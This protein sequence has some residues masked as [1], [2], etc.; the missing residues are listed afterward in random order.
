[1]SNV[2]RA[3]LPVVDPTIKVD[4]LFVEDTESGG[5]NPAVPPDTLPSNSSR[6]GAWVP[7]VAVRS[8]MFSADEIRSM[9]V[10]FSSKVPRLTFTIRD[11]SQKFTINFPLDGDVVSVYL[12]PPDK[13]NQRPV[14]MDFDILSV[15]SSPASQTYTF[16]CLLK[17]PGMF[18]E[19]CRSFDAAT[20]FDHLKSV[21][22]D[23][24]LGFASN[25]DST[26]D[27]MRRICAYDTYETFIGET[28]RTAYKDDDSFFTWFIDQF[29]YLCLVNVNKQFSE[30]D[31]TEDVNVSYSVPF[32]GVRSQGGAEDTVRGSLVLTNKPEMEGTNTYIESY[33]LENASASV[34]INNGYKRQAQYYESGNQPGYV[35]SFV[36]PLTTPGTEGDRILLKGRRDEEVYKR[37]VKH[38]WLG[39]QRAQSD[40]G[41]V[42]DNYLY[43][44]LHNHQ[45]MEEVGKTSLRVQLSGM[46]FYVGRWCRVPVLIYSPGSNF[47]NAALLK[48]RDADLGE[49]GKTDP[50]RNEPMNKL[51]GD[52]DA[53]QGDGLSPGDW[54]KNEFL[55]GYYV[56]AAMEYRY[57]PPGPVKQ[58]LTLVRREWPI[59]ALNK[60]V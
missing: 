53:S 9:A 37:T 31:S 24:G 50:G 5:A 45:N 57:S 32:A 46:N 34:W 39:K 59:P 28:V 52:S 47:K 60:D 27:S 36:D 17:V 1:M 35:K 15:S 21:C 8:I 48:K 49:D 54:V 33:S 30:E 38:V 58:V 18:G 51:S 25:V 12:R 14:R 40:G 6:A 41:H 56:V 4:P 2:D 19:V 20:S 11:V 22:A 55:S 10:S 42:H 7:V 44:A 43:A 23:V 29:Y 13:D 16:S 3:I 26:S